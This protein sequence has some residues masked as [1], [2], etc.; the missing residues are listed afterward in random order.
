MKE[1]K[2]KKE[3]SVFNWGWYKV[4]IFAIELVVFLGIWKLIDYCGMPSYSWRSISTYWLTVLALIYWTIGSYIFFCSEFDDCKPG[5]NVAHVILGITVV[6]AII[7]IVVGIK[8]GEMCDSSYQYNLVSNMVTKISSKTGGEEVDAA[9]AQ[10]FPVFDVKTI[11]MG[12]K[13]EAEAAAQTLL[14]SMPGLG[15]QMELDSDEYTSQNIN[16]ELCYVVPLE[17]SSMF[18]WD[19]TVGNGGY[20]I[21]NRNTR[22]TEF[23]QDSL[24]YVQDAPFRNKIKRHMYNYVHDALNLSYGIMDISPEVSTDGTY[25]YVGTVYDYSKAGSLKIVKGVVVTN[26]IT[27]ENEFYSVEEAPEW[28]DRIYPEE[29][30]LD[31]IKVYGK[32]ANGYWNASMFGKKKGVQIPTN[33]Y[34]VVYVNGTCYAYSGWTTSKAGA[35]SDS[36]NGIIMM[37][38]R[39]GEILLYENNG[40]SES[41]AQKVAQGKVQEK[42]YTASYPILI[43]VAEQPTYFMLMRD[44]SDNLTGYAFVNYKDYTKVAVSETIQDAQTAYIKA[45]AT[46]NSSDNLENVEL[47]TKKGVITNIANEVVES[48][49]VYYVQIDDDSTIFTFSSSVDKKVVF[50]SIGDDITISYIPADGAEVISAVEV[51]ITYASHEIKTE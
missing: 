2:V 34:D 42:E 12:G 21:F 32:Y 37:N 15:S 46:N 49:T 41:K 8:N 30:F 29:L 26:A 43:S 18:R 48:N 14:G 31:Y 13:P 51:D 38:L 10:V 33:D 47:S 22:K 19:K 11:P 3:N 5:K 24:F 50:A 1:K 4:V 35:S 7:A 27:G 40:I 45:L 39:T 9:N 44:K 16:N 17:P 36:S 23:V 20:F 25:Y 6:F 28:I